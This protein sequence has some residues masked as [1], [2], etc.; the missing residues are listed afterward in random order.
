MFRIYFSVSVYSNGLVNYWTHHSWWK[1]EI[2]RKAKGKEKARE[3]ERKR[4]KGRERNRKRKRLNFIAIEHCVIE[5]IIVL[6]FVNDWIAFFGR[7][8]KPISGD[9][10]LLLSHCANG[11]HSD[12]P[13]SINSIIAF[14]RCKNNLKCFPVPHHPSQPHRTYKHFIK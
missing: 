5:E 4:A 9:F 10:F 12:N 3:R 2:Y 1:A 8:S 7:E 11:K 13:I 14:R 6:C